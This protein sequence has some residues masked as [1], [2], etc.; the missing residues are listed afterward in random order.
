VTDCP[1]AGF[2]LMTDQV[3]K[4]C[5]DLN[6]LRGGYIAAVSRWYD[7]GGADPNLMHLP[8]AVAA[9]KNL[10][11]VATRLIDHRKQHGC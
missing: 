4:I 3:D 10:D 7:V 11:E 5:A 8:E 1:H 9:K 6:T 2:P